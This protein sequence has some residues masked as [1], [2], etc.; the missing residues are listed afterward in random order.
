MYSEQSWNDHHS[1]SGTQRFTRGGGIGSINPSGRGGAGGYDVGSAAAAG[2]YNSVAAARQQSPQPTS[3]YPPVTSRFT[4]MDF[5]LFINSNRDPTDEMRRS[6]EYYYWYHSK[7]PRDPRV[8]QPLP[9]LEV[10]ETFTTMETPWED[11][12]AMPSSTAVRAGTASGLGRKMGG[13]SL[14]LDAK[15][16]CETQEAQAINPYGHSLITESNMMSP[17]T[18]FFAAYAP[19]P[20]A[21][22]T[23]STLRAYA[24]GHLPMPSSGNRGSYEGEMAGGVTYGRGTAPAAKSIASQQYYT[25]EPMNAFGLYNTGVD[26]GSNYYDATQ[27][28]SSN[29]LGAGH[30]NPYQLMEGMGEV[31][32]TML[33]S[34]PGTDCGFQSRGTGRGGNRRYNN[35]S[36]GGGVGGGRV[37]RNNY[38]GGRG[39]GG[40]GS[41]ESGSGPNSH[42]FVGSEK[43]RMFRHDV[44]EQKTSQWRLDDLKGYAVEFAKDQEGSRFIQSAVDTASPES[45]DVLFHEIFESPLELVTDIFGNYV[46]QKL[47]DKGNTP[48]LTFAAER[49][50]GHVVELTMQTYGCRVIQKCIEV[51]PSAGLDIILAELK[52]NVAKCI[53]DQNGNHVI[54]KCVEVIPQRCGFIISAFSGRVMELATHAYGCRVIQCIMQHCPEQEDTIFN[55]LLKAVDVL[56]K[57][58]YGNYVIQH[59]LQNV[60]D[61]SK[62]ESVYAALKPKFFYLSKQKFASNVMEKLYARSSPANRME[63]VEMMCADFPSKADH[64]EIVAFKRSAT[65]TAA[66]VN[67]EEGTWPPT[68]SNADGTV[69]EVKEKNREAKD[70]AMGIIEEVVSVGLGQPSMLCLMMSDQYANYVVQRVLD[71]S[72]VDQFVKLVDNIEKYIL[73]IRTYTYGRPIVQRLSRR[74]LVLA[75]GDEAGEAGST[76]MSSH[77]HNEGRANHNEGRSNHNEGRA[78][79]HRR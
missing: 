78:N 58:Q 25:Q 44:A 47:L 28:S 34:Q 32:P 77:N 62:I 4:P 9:S 74:K 69:K 52:D 17:S 66:I 39:A 60:K 72:E 53:Q 63:I 46:L 22:A 67:A 55:E 33:Y 56:A 24:H 35:N 68:R 43:L 11:V 76:S 13:K 10:Q 14:A 75:P 41:M 49:M 65:K 38:R 36:A 64:V 31:D 8:P 1:V 30:G 71:A 59:V 18:Q 54:Q 79:H 5:E 21:M 3:F 16:L 7:Q 2:G 42:R 29:G 15:D 51:M 23:P 27:G 48:Q 70:A 12:S 57:D 37:G 26:P 45:L 50:C 61:E 40:M 20:L 6:Q 19:T 73:P